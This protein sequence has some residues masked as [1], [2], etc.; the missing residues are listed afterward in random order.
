MVG[1][2]INLNWSFLEWL[3]IAN[4][5]ESELNFI[6]WIEVVKFNID[7]CGIGFVSVKQSLLYILTTPVLELYDYLYINIKEW[8][9]IIKIK[10]E[11]YIY[12]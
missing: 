12:I 5:C 11:K 2:W 9:K 7:F 3:D 8:N 10:I 4:N 6:L 1:K